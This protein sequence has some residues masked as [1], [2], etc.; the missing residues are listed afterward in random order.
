MLFLLSYSAVLGICGVIHPIRSRVRKNLPYYLVSDLE[1]SC[2]LIPS[3][4]KII[5][6]IVGGVTGGV[7]ADELLGRYLLHNQFKGLDI[8]IIGITAVIG[9]R[10]FKNAMTLIYKMI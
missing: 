6:G 4:L 7:L 2:R 8:V 3:S 10:L 5:S 9:G 1:E